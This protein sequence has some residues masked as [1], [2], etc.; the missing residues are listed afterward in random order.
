MSYQHP[1]TMLH[2]MNMS[3]PTR[4]TFYRIKPVCE[5]VMQDPSPE[6]LAT[7]GN[8]VDELKIDTVQEL[9]QY[10]LFPFTNHLQYQGSKKTFELHLRMLEAMK[11][12]LLRVKVCH[13]RVC[14]RLLDLLLKMIFDKNRPG[15]IADVPEE[16]KLCVIQCLS[17]LMLNV[18]HETRLKMLQANVPLLAQA[19]FVSVHLAKL[20]KLRAL[21]LAAL[22]CLAVLT[23]TH[24]ELTDGVGHIT[25]PALEEVVVSMMACI[26]PGVLAALQDVAMCTDNPGHAVVAAALSAT[27]RVMCTIMNNRQVQQQDGVKVTDF[28]KLLTQKSKELK[29]VS[30]TVSSKDRPKRDTKDIPKRSPEWYAMASEKLAF[31]V[32]NLIPLVTH[33]HYKVR[34]ELAVLCYRILSECSST[35]Q[36]SLAM[37]LDV[38]I[39]L[40][41]DPYQEVSEYCTSAVHAHFASASKERLAEAIDS[42][43]ENFFTTLNCLPRILINID[44]SRKLSVLS[45]LYGYLK[46]LCDEGRPQRL[47]GAL[48]TSDGFDRL[49]DALLTAADL[50]TDLALLTRHAGRDVKSPPSTDTPWCRLRYLDN[51]ESE[52]RLQDVCQML[53]GAECA[54]LFLDRLLELFHEKRSSE[55]V[56]I[57]NWVGSA[58]NSTPNLAKRIINKYIEEDIWYLPLEVTSGEAPLTKEETRDPSIYNPRAWAKD[59][60]PGLYEGTTEVRYTDVSYM[61]PRERYVEPNT[62]GSIAEAQAN[63][64]FSCLVTEG[65][66]MMARRLGAD[67]QPFMLKTLCLILERV[68]SKYE[69]LHLTGLKAL[70]DVAAAFQRDSVTDLLAENADYFTNQITQRLKKAWRTQSALQVLSVVMEYSDSSILDYLYGIV[71]DVLI[72][73]CDKYYQRHLYA[74]LQVFLTF[75]TCIRK[76]FLVEPKPKPKKE[77]QT[78]EIDIMKDV[79]EFEKNKKES[80]RL[81]SEEKESNMTVEE[82]YKEDMKRKEEEMLN[83]DD[84]AVSEESP[85]LPHHIRVTVTILKRCVNFIA[86]GRDESLVALQILALGLPLLKEYEDEL[87]PLVHLCWA[88]LVAK[89]SAPEVLVLKSAFELFVVL[90]TLAKDFLR[91]RAVKDVL[92][93]MYKFLWSMAAESQLKDNGSAYRLSH[94]Y[95]LQVSVLGALPALVVD[96]GLQDEQLTEAMRAAQD[97]LS[98]KQPKPLQMLAVKFFQGVM[99]YN[100]GAAWY[101]LR[102]LCDNG[103]RHH[104]QY[105]NIAPLVTIVGTP[106]ESPDPDY[107]PNVKLIFY[108]H[109]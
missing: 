77:L 42:L 28:L 61:R 86:L 9:Q 8:V 33:E 84:T 107:D 34:K 45:L 85:P 4:E 72:Q 95:S 80:A 57:I 90:A 62:C 51:K 60:V 44:S 100:Y 24:P 14:E 7:F 104:S 81:L 68:G 13:F 29:D 19:I 41:T 74:Y 26:L 46:I 75:V 67:Y 6:H 22:N 79:I 50:Q 52:K 108:V 53:G 35:M 73:S 56:Y 10:L 92:Q 47:S 78:Q 69:N 37:T 39:T 32:K 94:M 88:P 65:L 38:M 1:K 3:P 98:A 66:G 99:S 55:L 64:A 15:M 25:D 20:E 58:P 96:L 82:M 101:H 93:P 59:S 31:V 63:M 11:E 48:S 106:Y 16:L 23:V 43:C 27:H 54:E 70:H 105:A 102:A 87:L 40:S 17:T 21:R 36:P 12:V 97:Y 103:V 76:W 109:K 2:I 18:D 49:C 89:F 5:L 30:T 91:S 71:E 83:D